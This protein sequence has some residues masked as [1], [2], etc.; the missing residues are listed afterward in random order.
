[1]EASG[2]Q[3][4]ILEDASS[5]VIFRAN[6]EFKNYTQDLIMT[7]ILYADGG[8]LGQNGK[9]FAG[10]YWSVYDENHSRPVVAKRISETGNFTTNN[11]A[12]YLAFVECLS[13]LKEH[14]HKQATIRMDSQLVVSQVT[15]KWKVKNKRLVY[16]YEQAIKKMNDMLRQGYKIKLEWV[17]RSEL[18]KRLGH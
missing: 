3:R 17:P 13:F 4:W 16:L 7:Q 9:T 18:V 15:G 8:T 12:E 11:E 14:Q 6:N 1:L 5:C 2:T 10:I